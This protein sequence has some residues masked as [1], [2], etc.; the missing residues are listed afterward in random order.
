MR[1]YRIHNLKEFTIQREDESGMCQQYGS[2]LLTIQNFHEA[3]A[4]AAL[5]KNYQVNENIWIRLEK[6]SKV[7]TTMKLLIFTCLAAVALARPKPPL[8]HQEHLQNEPDSREELF[9]ERK[10]LRFPEV[11]LSS[12]FRQEIINELNRNHG[13]EGREQRGSS[14]SSSEEVVGNSAEVRYIY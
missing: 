5:I 2:H 8:R 13:M 11:P 12:Q 3:S 1:L 9:K 4:I 6:P 7:L 10:F 14:S